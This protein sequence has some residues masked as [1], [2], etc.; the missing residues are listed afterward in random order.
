MPNFITTEGGQFFYPELGNFETLESE[1]L[2]MLEVQN[3][4]DDRI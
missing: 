3:I 2:T 1:A 4:G